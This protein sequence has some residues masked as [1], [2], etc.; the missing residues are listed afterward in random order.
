M[1]YMVHSIHD[2][3][4]EETILPLT[5]IY[6]KNQQC[7]KTSYKEKENKKELADHY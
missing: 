5:C 7:S 4:N 3:V 2:I 1:V 6:R